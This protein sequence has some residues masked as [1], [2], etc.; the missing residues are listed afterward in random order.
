M[1]A[2]A[3]QFEARF[4]DRLRLPFNFDPARLAADLQNLAFGRL[5][6]PLRP[7]E[8]RWRL[9]GHS[10]AGP[11]RRATS[12]ADDLFRPGAT[13]FKDTP[14]LDACPYFREVV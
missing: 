5:D 1:T 11:R 6:A 4:P 13:D 2:V 8:L 12:L 10:V 3:Q 9:V 7:A 14:L